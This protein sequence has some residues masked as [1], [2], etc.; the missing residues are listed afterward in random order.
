MYIPCTVNDLEILTVRTK[1][2]FHN[3]VF[4]SKLATTCFGLIVAY[5]CVKLRQ[6]QWPRCLRR[7][8]A[9]VRLL[10][11]WVRILPEHGCLL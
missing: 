11:S 4:H 9:A 2:Q 8:S 7:T 5:I 3:Y 1:A 10:R 6:S